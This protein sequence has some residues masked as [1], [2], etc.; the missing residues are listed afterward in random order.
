M[1]N[2]EQQRKEAVAEFIKDQRHYDKYRVFYIALSVIVIMAILVSFVY[3]RLKCLSACSDEGYHTYT[4]ITQRWHPNQ[5][6]CQ[7]QED[8]QV[9][10][11][12]PRGKK[13]EL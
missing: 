4:Y 9:L 6:I 10:K 3:P 8:S 5:C 13:I 7:T 1:K 2:F 12:Y 11:G